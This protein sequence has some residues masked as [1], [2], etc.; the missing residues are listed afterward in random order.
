MVSSELSRVYVWG[1]ARSAEGKQRG[2]SV[3]T[4]IDVGVGECQFAQDSSFCPFLLS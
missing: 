4:A 2:S 3:Q 1:K